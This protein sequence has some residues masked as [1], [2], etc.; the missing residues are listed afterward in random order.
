MSPFECDAALAV[1]FLD[2]PPYNPPYNKPQVI[3][4]EL[5]GLSDVVF[6]YFGEQKPYWKFPVST[7]VRVSFLPYATEPPGH[8][9]CGGSDVK[10]VMSLT[11]FL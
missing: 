5:F 10:G 9:G 1:W 11:T 8:F 7:T 4:A 3:Q 2:D 6:A